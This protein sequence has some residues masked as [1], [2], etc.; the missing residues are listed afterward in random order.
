MKFI[1]SFLL[2]GVLSLTSSSAFVVTSKGVSSPSIFAPAMQPLVVPVL[3]TSRGTIRSTALQMA[4]PTGDALAANRKDEVYKLIDELALEGEDAGEAKKLIESVLSSSEQTSVTVGE[5]AIATLSEDEE[6]GT[7]ILSTC[8]DALFDLTLDIVGLLMTLVGLPSKIGKRAA[9]V[10]AKKARKKLTKEVKRIAKQ[11]FRDAGDLMSIA[12]GVWEFMQALLKI[13]SIDAIIG[14]IIGSMSWW[15]V[16]LYAALVTAQVALLFV[17]NVA[18]IVAK[19][20]LATPD[21]VDVVKSTVKV[22]D[23]C[24]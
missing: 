24:D 23:E 1:N 17:G 19:L 10:I 18:T 14:A 11:Y 9:K 21:I 5:M 6:E 2:S 16:P 8:D 20:A 13:L 22:I 15:E 3:P 12:T 4:L 7:K